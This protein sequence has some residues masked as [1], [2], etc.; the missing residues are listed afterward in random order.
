MSKGDQRT[1]DDCGTMMSMLITKGD[2]HGGMKTVCEDRRACD[3]RADVRAGNNYHR[4]QM[5]PEPESPY[6]RD[7]NT[8]MK[9]IPGKTETSE[10]MDIPTP[11]TNGFKWTAFTGDDDFDSLLQKCIE[12]LRVKGKDYTIGTGDRLHNFKTV[13]EF[14]GMTPEQSLGVYLYK[15]ISAIFAYIKKGDQSESEPIEGRVTDVINYML[16]FHKMIQ[17]RKRGNLK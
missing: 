11:P 16:L 4:K 3:V 10:G 9:T 13:G 2:H 5:K 7:Y 15:H 14:T 17:E 6:Q 8:Y 12:V 1:C